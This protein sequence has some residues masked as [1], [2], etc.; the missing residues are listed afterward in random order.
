MSKNNTYQLLFE[1]ADEPRLI[2]ESKSLSLLDIN[3]Q[4][5]KLLG[6]TKSKTKKYKLP[7]FF[8]QDKRKVSVA[9]FNKIKRKRKG[10]LGNVEIQ[11]LKGKKF[12]VE[13]E[14]TKI[15][16]ED[17]EVIECKVHN[18]NKNFPVVKHDEV[19]FKTLFESANDAILLLNNDTF[20][21]CNE[22]TLEIFGCSRNEIINKKIHKFSPRTQPDGN[23]S[24]EIAL[25]KINAA[26]D[27]IPQFFEWKH[28]KADGTLFDTE[29]TLNR[30]VLENQV[31]LHAIIRDI[32]DKKLKESTIREQNRRINTLMGNLPGMAYRCKLN[33]KWTMEFVSEGC[34]SLT[35][36]KPEDFIN[37]STIAYNNIIHPEDR[38]RLW[39]EINY[40]LEKKKPFTILY[41]I[42]TR[43]GFEKWLWEKGIG[44]YND[45]GEIIALEGFIS[46]ITDRKLSEEK[47][48]MLAHA[49][50]SI[51]ECVWIMDMN[52]FIMFVNNSFCKTYGY[53]QDEIIGKK[54]SIIRSPN[55]SVQL[56]NKVRSFTFEDGWSGELLDIKKSGEEFPV[57]LSTSIIK[58]DSEK[59]IALIGITNDITERKKAEEALR[60]SEERFKSLVDN[61]L[62]PAIILGMNGSILFANNSAAHLVE[63]HSPAEANGK[64]IFEFLHPD[65]NL[66]LKRTFIKAKKNP[67]LFSAEFKILTLKNNEKWVEGLGKEIIFDGNKSVLI[68]LHDISGRKKAEKQLKEAKEYAEEM[69]KL[70]SAFLANMSHELR[71]PL[72]GILGYSEMLLEKL[73]DPEQ[74]DMIDKILFSGNRLMETLNSVLDLSRIEA[75]RIDIYL[76]PINVPSI[77]KRHAEIF[78]PTA[79]KR[80]LYLHTLFSD[81][82]I[83]ALLDERFLGQII[84]NLVS[85]SIKFTKKGGI[86]IRVDTIQNA[87]EKLVQIS[88]SD[89]GIGIPQKNLDTI[90]EEF[91]QVSEGIN[92][93][94]E[95][96]GL[97]LTITKR[98]VKLMDGKINVKSEVGSG[99]EFVITFT[100][101]DESV[102]VMKPKGEDFSRS[103][104]TQ[105]HSPY[106]KTVPEVLFVEDDQSSKDITQLFLEGIC[107]LTF[108]KTGEE[109]L[110]IVRQKKYDAILMDIN[111]G[112]GISGVETTKLIRK[113]KDY[114]K[115]PII[116]ITAFAMDGDKDKFLSCGCTHYISKPYDRSSISKLI[117]NIFENQLSKT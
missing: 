60:Q 110:E 7:H 15:R 24:K 9:R 108:A 86:T 10:I 55:N 97:G 17:K 116:A 38:D 66:Q 36:Y 59:P 14:T 111:L 13:I 80:G 84:N 101:L 21:D 92:R 94:F 5:R 51:S 64:D 91:R 99:S 42:Y 98:F 117:K 71:T 18:Q 2:L 82:N 100:A 28:K 90:F 83:T 33:R 52:E 104:I 87:M 44:I 67:D 81:E 50:K 58:D 102:D 107:D 35:G 77:V 11:N 113:M 29:V 37:D 65:F 34:L 1:E 57:L 53:E 47:I 78:K 68:T 112:S 32:T 106:L 23:K 72:V 46:D 43:D 22:K 69:N 49:L 89:T 62:E 48:S 40:A 16:V 95:G 4:A 12:N 61:M 8:P 6:I 19:K 114:K 85:N 3:K 27:D 25:E 41:R 75:N 73:K 20:L 93:H 115:I 96:T 39:I 103:V 63:I 56:I 79:E 105:N 30:V 74:V 45:S 31:M 88:V 54:I 109:A 76:E 70:K 26:L